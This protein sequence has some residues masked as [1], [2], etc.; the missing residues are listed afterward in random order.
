MSQL[1][2]T[3]R[4]EISRDAQVLFEQTFA[5]KQKVSCK[6]LKPMIRLRDKLH[7]LAFVDKGIAPVVQRLDAGLMQIPRQGSLEGEALTQLMERVLLLCSPEQMQ[8]CAESLA[9][10]NEPVAIP[11]QDQPVKT[12]DAEETPETVQ[13]IV[14]ETVLKKVFQENPV[15]DQTTVI[16]AED[17]PETGTFYF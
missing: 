14:Q 6:A 8:R 7:S 10:V 1:G 2:H 12:E 9:V 11:I 15:E 5:G 13:E 16:P 3:L 17:K 4:D